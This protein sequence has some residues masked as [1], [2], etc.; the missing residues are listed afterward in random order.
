[1]AHSTSSLTQELVVPCE[2]GVH[3]RMAAKI[4]EMTKR[5]EA[6]MWL[7]SGNRSARANSILG[8]LELGAT[9]GT[10]LL[11]GADGRDAAEAIGAMA[12]LFASDACGDPSH[13]SRQPATEPTVNG[14]AGPN[15]RT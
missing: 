2:H 15:P 5:F 6:R 3:L 8:L 13:T 9:Q 7:T 1:M 10:R 14:N 4:V 11:V 12:T